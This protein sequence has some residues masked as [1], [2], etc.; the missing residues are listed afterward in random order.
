MATPTQASRS[1]QASRTATKSRKALAPRARP[2]LVRPGARF[3]CFGDGLCC[4]DIHVLGEITRKEASDM[5]RIARESVH[6]DRNVEGY[7]LQVV[8][9]R[10]HFLGKGGCHVHATQGADAKPLGCR[11]FPFGLVNTPQGGRIT[12]EHRCPCRT[13]GQRPPIDPTEAEQSLVDSAGRLVTD[14]VV[15]KRLKLTRDKSVGFE[16]YAEQE[17]TL[18][19]ALMKGE[20]PLAVLDAKPFPLLREMSWPQAAAEFLDMQDSTAGGMALTWFGDAVLSIACGH[21]PPKRE[22][23]WQAAFARAVKRKGKDDHHEQAADWMADELWM[24]RWLQWERPFDVG[25]AELATRF[26][27][28][29][30][31]AYWLQ[32]H[33]IEARQATAEAIMIVDVATAS[34]EWPGVVE[35]MA[36]APDAPKRLRKAAK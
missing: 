4:T 10:C 21:T 22:R 25:R 31:L 24:M 14:Q 9:H 29:R 27:I 5:R 2:L 11:R 13:L 19:A 33:G 17:A 23:P 20:D 16:A 15:P 35:Q 3:A 12:T 18:I 28:L 30:L 6:F 34:S 8:D 7:A 26:A 32:Q 1:T 36:V